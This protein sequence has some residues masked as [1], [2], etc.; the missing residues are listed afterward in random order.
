[1]KTTLKT[2]HTLTLAALTLLLAGQTL[3]PLMIAE[4]AEHGDQVSL[5]LIME[6]AQCL[7][8]TITSCVHVID[9]DMVLLGGAMTF[10][11]DTT[12]VGREFMQRVRQEFRTRTFP[13]LAEKITIDWASLGGDAGFI[14]A[15]GCARRAVQKGRLSAG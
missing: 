1:M 14:G 4:E 12:M 6:M 7:G 10:G 5:E 11:R 9:P 3:T 15:A 2:V 8:A 13:T